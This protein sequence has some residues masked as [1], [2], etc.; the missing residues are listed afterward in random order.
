MKYLVNL[1]GKHILIIGGLSEIGKKTAETLCDLDAIV[2]IAD[3]K[4]SF[5]DGSLSVLKN[6]RN[7]YIQIDAADIDSIGRRIESAVEKYGKY[8]GLVYAA[9]SYESRTV[10]NSSP[11]VIKKQFD[12]NYFGFFEAIRQI[13][14]QGRYNEGMRIVGLSSV[15][16]LKGKDTYSVYSASKA[17]MDGA[18]RSLA[19]ELAEKKIYINTV[20]SGVVEKGA[21][22]DLIENA[23]EDNLDAVILKERQSLGIGDDRRYSGTDCISFK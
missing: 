21:F 2:D 12:I 5:D 18:V 22:S 3:I 20:V 19:I 7:H 10:D 13:T 16:S 1:S 15:A 23:P 9:E 4:E 17:A 8:D 6:E 11:E 14:V